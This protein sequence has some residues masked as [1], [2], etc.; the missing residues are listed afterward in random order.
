MKQFVCASSTEFAVA[1]F[2]I[3]E[4][5]KKKNSPCAL[6][7]SRGRICIGCSRS[8]SLFLVQENLAVFTRRVKFSPSGLIL[9]RLP[10]CFAGSRGFLFYFI[11]FF[12]PK[13][14]LAKLV[15]EVLPPG[16]ACDRVEIYSLVQS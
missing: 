14:N 6:Y 4:A 10:R 7:L 5:Y 1:F 8:E 15:H 9:D 3:I 13:Q 11:A 2:Q 12:P 16:Q